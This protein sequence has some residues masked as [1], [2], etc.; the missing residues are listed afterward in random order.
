MCF[1]LNKTILSG[2]GRLGEN[3][4]R[5]MC[6]GT[7]ERGIG[8]VLKDVA[9]REGNWG[10]ANASRDKVKWRTLGPAGDYKGSN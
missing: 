9:K 2:G 6:E 5:D 7:P 3:R 10:R 8:G 1:E 4:H